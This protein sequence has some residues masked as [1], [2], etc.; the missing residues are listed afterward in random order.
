MSN[1]NAVIL[2]A[3][4]SKD[5]KHKVRISVAHNG[6]TRYIPT[7]IILDSANEFKKGSIVK[8]PDAAFLNTKLRG[9]LQHYQ[10][11][12]DEL[13][14]IN[15]FSCAELINMIKTTETQKYRTLSSV[16]D[17]Y[18][19]YARIKD[20]S[21]GTYSTA[22]NA[23]TKYVKGTTLMD[24]LTPSTVITIDANLRKKGLGATTIRNYMI[25]F[26]TVVNYAVK[27]GYVFYRV[28]PFA[29][30][31]FPAAKI[32]QSWISTEEVK[33]IRD[34]QTKNVKL[35]R[36]RDFFMLSYYLG[37]I[38][39]VDLKHIAFDDK[40]RVI[41]YVRQKVE[42]RGAEP[43]KVEFNIPDEAWSIIQ[44]YKGGTGIINVA[45]CNKKWSDKHFISYHM[46]KLGEALNI[47][48]LIYYSARKSFA[49]HAF[50]LGIGDAVIDYFLGHSGKS[51]GGPSTYFYRHVTPEMATDALRL[52][53]D[54]LK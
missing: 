27:S 11:L 18:K 39:I 51:S 46:K 26:K 47:P 3:K 33:A 29:S 25:I 54:N 49:Q 21:R 12:I 17:E 4:A 43:V 2:P 44:K 10:E 30:Y 16:I 7:S 34:F 48:N 19:E 42:T 9:I 40:S 24:H 6:T 38:N 52:V 13:G 23:I 31:K 22:W 50:K 8:R 1:L 28:H 41:K 5:G 37:G 53:L 45:V 36:C 32:R 35:A 14:F 15:G 20:S